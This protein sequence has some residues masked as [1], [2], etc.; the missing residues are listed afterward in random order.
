MKQLYEL[1][2]HQKLI[3]YTEKYYPNTS[4]QV[5]AGTVY[6]KTEIDL[7]ILGKAVNLVVKNNDGMRLRVLE[8]EVEPKQYV[9]DYEE[10]NIDVLDFSYSNSEHDINRWT[11]NETRTPFSIV[12]SKLYDFAIIKVNDKDVRL[13]I[14][15]HHLIS[16]ACTMT[17]IVNQTVE[18]YSRLKNG[19]DGFEA[20]P[21]Y[22]NFIKNEQEYFES[23]RYFKDKEY[24]TNQARYFTE[25]TQIKE[26]SADNLSLRAN[27]KTISVPAEFTEE[28]HQYCSQNRSSVYSLFVSILSIYLAKIVGKSEINLGTTTLNRSTAN[29]KD[30]IGL[31][32]NILPTGL[33]V[34]EQSQF[35]SFMRDAT[36]NSMALLRHQKYPY[37]Y[38]L[39][40]IRELNKSN[41]GLFDVVLNYQVSKFNKGSQD[42]EYTTE[43]HFTGNQIESL[44]I[45]ISDRE[46][47]GGL[48]IEYDYLTDL[49]KEYEIISLHDRLI[50][51]VVQVISNSEKKIC[52]LEMITA[53]E[54]KLIVFNF[55]DTK[56]D[57]PRKKTIHQLFEEQVLMTP[58]NIAVS[59]KNRT[60]TYRELNEEANQL[61]RVIRGKGV[62]SDVIVGIMV[63]RSLEMIIGILAILKAGGAYL[64][65]DYEYPRDR[66]EY[67]LEDSNAKLLLSKK[68]LSNS[69]S[70]NGDVICLDD[71]SIFDGEASNLENVNKPS[72]LAYIIYTSGSTGRPKGTMIEHE[73]V[74]RLLF[75]QKFQFSF[76]SDD[77]WTMFH[78]FCFDFSVWEM[79][80]A[81]LYG[82]K[83]IVIPKDA[84]KS[85]KD[86][87]E[88]LKKEKVTVLNQTPASF[89][90]LTDEE[91]ESQDNSLKLN[92]VI[93]G[94]EALK[95]TMLK[96]F[97]D[98]YPMTKL[99]NM[100]GIT[101][102]TVHVTYKDL[103]EADIES[104]ISNIGKPIPT[105]TVYI[106]DKNLNLVPIGIPGELCVGGDG[107]AR[108][109]LNRPDL[110]AEKFIKNPFA[111]SD[112]LYKSG[113]LARWLPNGDIEYLGRIDQQVKIRGFRVELGEIESRLLEHKDVRSAV[114]VARDDNA[115]KY[116]CAYI[117]S[118]KAISITELRKHINQKLPDYMIPSHFVNLREIPL[119]SN[120][121]VDKKALPI[122]TG[123][124]KLDTKYVSPRNIFE[125]RLVTVWSK[126]LNIKKIGIDDNFFELGGDSLKIVEVLSNI[127]KFNWGL[128]IQDFYRFPTIRELSIK[129]DKRDSISENPTAAPVS[130]EAVEMKEEVTNVSNEELPNNNIFLTGVTGFLGIHILRDL[131]INTNSNIYCLIRGDSQKNAEEKL[132]DRLGFYFQGQYTSLIGDRIIIVNGDITT[133][134]FGLSESAYCSLGNKIDLIIHSA[135]IV[136]YFGDYSEI[137]LVNVFGTQR[138]IE[139]ALKYSKKLI[140][141]STV[142]IS[143]S[144]LVESSVTDTIL[145]ENDFFV[146]Q[147]YLDNIYI[148]SKFEAENLIIKAMKQGLN[149]TI[150]RMGNLSGRYSDGHF[151]QNITENAFYR[152][153]RSIIQIGVVPEGL[154][155]E[156]IEITP[157]DDASLALVKLLMTRESSGRIFHVFDH[158][159]IKFSKMIDMLVNIGFDIK[160]VN[161][162]EFQEYLVTISSDKNRQNELDGIINDINDATGL[163]YV[164]PIH[165]DSKIT[166]RY[167]KILDF[168]WPEINEEYIA[169]I[170]QH[171]KKV[172]FII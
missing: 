21:S 50:N 73:N 149:A 144:Y 74:V 124:V 24:W 165:I 150:M 87:L 130:I 68:S 105:L 134:R 5:I 45:N 115:D 109:Y 128:T 96:P 77:V 139:F 54:R 27:R 159:E 103:S 4:L 157:I 38:I 30:T 146:G 172:G 158:Y 51:L 169:K 41:D 166:Q 167:L 113:D 138:V 97:R 140:H 18:Y 67:M 143:G 56:A 3:W 162:K 123:E 111:S 7:D 59:F 91:A 32:T 8:L 89:Y 135:A 102:T 22:V 110:S 78:S 92:Y 65:I 122:P 84:A 70:Y 95:P 161:N 133:D 132:M 119:T 170:I 104:S 83:L 155:E 151:Q 80:G 40:D 90:N 61:A 148:R 76:S 121:K 47:E 17:I 36:K 43:W 120:G 127:L 60:I 35:S 33:E 94:G 152:T 64:P 57:F 12:D 81:L 39:K 142:G 10:E 23:N 2:H 106:V 53:E 116:L 168:E 29:E 129:I 82:G 34:K 46:N 42:L 136:K 160:I 16:D 31:F 93:F 71:E 163:G 58:D 72:D 126:V 20:N 100:Y 88:I 145:T 75:N 37:D 101:E 9:A 131:I 137:E 69:I 6:F 28:I 86:F 11:D 44:I 153:I 66:I 1:S 13:Y 99:I 154:M 98:K 25:K 19:E 62:C 14:K 79:Y 171:M 55:N 26:R 48:I 107:V 63:E 112:R 108:G 85:P 118:D 147:N 15:N 117:V 164:V 125:K 114:V 141:I 156:E 52:E 49:F